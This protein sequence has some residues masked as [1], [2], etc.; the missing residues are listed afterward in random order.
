[1]ENACLVCGTVFKVRPY[2]A[3]V[4]KYCS[5]E[6]KVLANTITKPCPTCGKDFVIWKSRDKKGKGNGTWCSKS[7]MVEAKKSKP[8]PKK[9]VKP[10]V[11]KIC[12]TCDKAFRVPPSREKSARWCSRN[13]QSKSVVFRKECSEA[14]VSGERHPRWTGKYQHKDGYVRLTKENPLF[15]TVRAE[16]TA[17]MIQ[18][19]L[20]VDPTNPFLAIVNGKVRLLPGVDVH[21]VDR[22][23][24]NN[25]RSNLI[26]II[27]T[28]H[29]QIHQR[30]R[31]PEPWECWPRN[32]PAW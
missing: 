20:E 19:M 5:Q 25:V 13:C 7:C 32:P 4:R 2:L 16:H 14:Q 17:V 28:A 15:K 12:E 27:A 8:K 26:A 30:G 18:W 1:M 10:P 23:R 22:N 21:H 24:S 29:T 3:E 6:C 31:K 9:V 11:L